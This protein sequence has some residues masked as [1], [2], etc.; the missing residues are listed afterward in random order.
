[1]EEVLLRKIHELG[2]EELKMVDHLNVLN[3]DYINLDLL[4]MR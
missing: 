3:G 2:I 4:L 1:M